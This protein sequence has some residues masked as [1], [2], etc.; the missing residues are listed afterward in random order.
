MTTASS[1]ATTWQ[2]LDPH[3]MVDK[4]LPWNGIHGPLNELGEEC[5]WPWD[6]QQLEGAPLGQYHCPYCGGMVMAGVPHLDWREEARPTRWVITFVVDAQDA[7]AAE[8]IADE[9]VSSVDAVI[10]WQAIEAE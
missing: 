8:S 9:I 10:G 1:A 2:D 4:A 6:P 5:P 3:D 7:S